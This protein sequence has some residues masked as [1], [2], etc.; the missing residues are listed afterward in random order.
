MDIRY[1]K[2]GDLENIKDIWNYCF[3]DE[4]VFV[5]Y[6]FNNKYKSKNTILIE[7]DGDLMSSLQLNQYKIKLNN[8]T[9]DTSYIVGVSTYPNARGKGYMK[10]MMEFS[11]NE[12]YKKGQ[13]VS[14]LMPI[15]YRLYR[16]YGYEHC[17]DQIEY[18]VDINDLKQFKINGDF[19]KVKDKHIQDMINI[20]N[21]FLSNNNGYVVR[22]KNYYNNLFK[23][24]KCE[25]GHMYIHKDENYDGYII[26]F[27]MEDTMFV[28][29][30]CYKNI[31]ALNSMLKFIFNHNTQ[32]KKVTIISSITDSIRYILPN[33]K[34]SEVNIK[35]FMMGRV[36]NIKGFI[37]SLKVKCN[38]LDEAYI[39]VVDNQIEKN[40][41]VFKLKVEDNKVSAQ[42]TSERADITLSINDISQLAFSYITLDQVLF[43]NNIEKN[44][45]NKKAIDLLSGIFNKSNNYVNEY[46]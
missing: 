17:Y 3:G 32:C 34:T 30:I 42:E 37:D 24:I 45:K 46:V 25:N 43:L 11:L 8:N 33:L 12:L 7:E 39:G 35:P 40:N 27:I 1:A 6:Y 38:N 4:E 18:K 13:L 10:D 5:D 22:D 20:Y 21:D 31:N 26:Y 23:E 14:L 29:E 44:K 2:D 36:I 15:D 28:R 41:K 9:Y 19:E 16:K